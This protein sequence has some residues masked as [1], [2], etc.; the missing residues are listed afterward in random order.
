MVSYQW[1]K[2]QYG[3]V[4]REETVLQGENYKNGMVKIKSEGERVGVGASIFRY[5]SQ[6]EENLVNKIEELDIKIDEAMENETGILSSDIKVLDGKIQKSLDTIYKQNNLA[7]ISEIKKEIEEAISKKA[8]ITGEQSPSGS[9]VKKLID[10]RKEYEYKL[11]SGTEDV[12]TDIAGIVSYKIDGLETVFTPDDFSKINK[13]ALNDL[14]L[15][16][17]QTIE[18]S[19]ESG[20]I[21]NNF[22]FYI[23]VELSSDESKKTKVREKRKN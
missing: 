8:N 19:D 9:Y 12:K 16:T 5:Y 11:N 20:K 10:E 21:I 23:A 15:K 13:Q 17:G 3:Y 1:K 18:E 6:D 7:K 22:K 14:N 2:K 4:I